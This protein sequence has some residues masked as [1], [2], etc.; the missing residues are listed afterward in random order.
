MCPVQAEGLAVRGG[1]LSRGRHGEAQ[2]HHWHGG[3][4]GG[5][6]Q[7]EAAGAGR[8]HEEGQADQPGRPAVSGLGETLGGFQHLGLGHGGDA[9][10]DCQRERGG[11]D[12]GHPAD[13]LCQVRQWTE[14]ARNVF[15]RGILFPV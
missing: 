10:R 11:L 1:E 8:R 9:L 7:Q 14:R 5:A 15:G 3:R 2:P 6:L 13:H 12:Q 4:R